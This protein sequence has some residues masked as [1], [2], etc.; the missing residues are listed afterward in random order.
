MDKTR[1]SSIQLFLLISGFLYGSSVILTPGVGAGRD[2]WLAIILGGTAGTLLMWVYAAIAS[3]NP[4]K[5]L[6]D[7][8]REK[9]G[10]VIGSI[11]SVLYIWYFIHLASLVFRN[12]GEFI[13]TTTY[14]ETPMAVVIGILALVLLYAVNGGI[15]V[16]GRLSELLV[17]LVPLVVSIISLSLIT[18][19]DFTAFLPV[20]E[21]G[22]APVVNAAFGY[23]TFPFGETIV[24]LMVFSNLNR[25]EKLKK[26]VTTSSV[27]STLLT[28]LV[29]LRDLF[30]LG[31]DLITRATFI[32]HLTSLLIPEFNVDPLVDIN[33]LI[34]GGIKISVCIYA[35]SRALSQV[36]GIDEYR[37]LSRAV[38][39]FCAVLSVWVYENLI[40][41]FRWAQMI[42]PYYSIPFQIIIPLL[43]L[44][45][46][47]LGKNK[48]S[49]AGEGR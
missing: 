30:A 16:L 43:V 27:T 20:L 8:L 5:T 45:L 19:N 1:I 37:T 17:P 23:L 44:L 2:A 32:P 35:A 26:V 47:L 34:A 41:M 25:R 39:T 9:M 12:F 15:E 10:K 11:L 38:C 29:F 6:V 31:S 46:S 24:F 40:E 28:L 21:N 36:A 7:I 22:M 18:V 4:S 14:P 3:L 48:P 33:L 49:K 42:W 13:C